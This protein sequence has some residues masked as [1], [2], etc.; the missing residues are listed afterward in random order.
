MFCFQATDERKRISLFKLRNTWT[1]YIP[2]KVLYD[3]DVRSKK[4]DPNWPLNRP[5]ETSAS[6]P[7][8]KKIHVNPKFL[9]VCFIQCYCGEKCLLEQLFLMKKYTFH[10]KW[11]YFFLFESI[12]K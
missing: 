6:I 1:Q 4:T 7:Q 3:L 10:G 12:K 2:G 8:Q 11:Y 5:S 9:Q